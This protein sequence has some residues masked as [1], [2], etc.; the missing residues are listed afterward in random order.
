MSFGRRKSKKRWRRGSA[1]MQE[2]LNPQKEWAKTHAQWRKECFLFTLVSLVALIGVIL[3][4]IFSSESYLGL[5]IAL[6]FAGTL[7]IWWALYFITVVLKHR[8]KELRFY[9][10]AIGGLSETQ[11]LTVIDFCPT[12]SFSKDGLDARL[13]KTCFPEKGKTYERDLYVLTG[14]PS[15]AQGSHIKA[16]SFGNVLLAYEVMR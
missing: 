4:I 9:Q 10:A 5:E 12:P 13:L 8:L 14:D 6:I 16:V 11:E 3:A 15:F 1:D 7:Y 2:L